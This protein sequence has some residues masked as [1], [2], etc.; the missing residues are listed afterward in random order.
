MQR[1]VGAFLGSAVG[2]ALGAPFEFGPAGAYT[3][4]FPE[5]VI[6]GTGE[7]IGGG[8]FIWAPGEF[9]DDTQ[10]AIALGESIV[11]CN[12][13]DADDVWARFQAWRRG[14]KDCGSLTNRA[15][16]NPSWP[17]AAKDAHHALRR[18]SAANGSLMRVTGLSCAYA[19]GDEA[20][21]IAAARAQSALTHLDPAAGWGA[22]IGA[23]LIRRF[24]LGED[25]LAAIPALLE[26]IDEPNRERFTEMLDPSW[27]PHDPSDVS[28]GSVWGCLAQAVW[29]VRTND[30]FAGA[31]IAAIDLGGDTDTVAAVAG[32]LA[33]ARSSVQG[34]PSRWL[35]YLNGVVGTGDD[36][37]RYDN[38]A[39]QDLARRLAGRSPVPATI[40][41]SPAGPT[42]VAPGLHA[43]DLGGAATVPT[44]WAI[45]S[46]CRT[47]GRFDGHAIRREVHLI[48]QAGAANADPAAAVRD[49]VDSIDAFLA[50][51]R[52]VVVHCH[53]GRSRTGLV[54][55]AWA[56]Q[57]NGW[58]ERQA[59][60]WLEEKWSRYEDYQISFVQLLSQ[61]W[62]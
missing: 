33:G 36:T 48:D 62:S 9:T 32:A 42:E 20:T 43:A 14:A 10:M 18:R 31:V 60:A 35:T 27:S 57:A 47:H 45:V 5:P 46:M 1:L 34:I 21:L 7:L 44:D 61:N 39:L 28:N 4:R 24:I 17:G 30:T 16:S 37:V 23:A 19:A 3:A 26:L 40:T 59:H 6:G 22:A 53:G 58:D 13:F 49:A 41:E 51:G 2:D 38:A 52:T 11:A 25:A 12:G 54:L 29:A 55:K 15:L 50:E 56:M 8:P